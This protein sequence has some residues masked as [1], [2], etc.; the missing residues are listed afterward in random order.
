MNRILNLG[1]AVGLAALVVGCGG[2]GSGLVNQPNARVQF[3]NL[4][5][6]ITSAKAKVGDDTISDDIPFGAVSDNAITNN[7]SKDLTVGDTTFDNLATLPN[8]VF[9]VEHRYT[10]VGYGT[11]PRA[12]LLI[13]H[14]KSQA[15][16]GTVAIR[17]THVAQGAGAMDVYLSAVGDSLPASPSFDA[18][19][20]AG[21]S[22][23]SELPVT[24]TNEY[25]IRIYAD[26]DTTTALVDKTV[27]I[28]SRERYSAILFAD[29]GEAS[30]YNIVLVKES[31]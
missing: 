10:G 17:A 30:G 4:M 13:D 21:T 26:D 24:G 16:N 19:A 8:Q 9:Q 31:I 27:V 28:Q 20:E 18:L 5:P 7:Q 2:S 6:G 23:F 22:S 12:I 14:N 29:A 3:A 11:A 15:A 1:M 25:R